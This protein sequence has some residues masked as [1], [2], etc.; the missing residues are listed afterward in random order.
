MKMETELKGTGIREGDIK[1][2]R[3]LFTEWIPKARYAWDAGVAIGRFLEELKNGR[4]VGTECQKCRRIMMPPRMF[5]ELCYLPTDKWKYVEDKGRVR[6]FCISRV[7]WDA[8]RVKEP[9]FPSVIELDGGEKGTAILHLVRG[10]HPEEM[11]V[12]LRVKAVWKAPEDRIGAIT[13]IECFI[14][15]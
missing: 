7:R 5:C 2:R 12:G 8:S 14:P 1:E 11:M 3:I 6:T 10:V 9:F 4:I 15:E 13:D